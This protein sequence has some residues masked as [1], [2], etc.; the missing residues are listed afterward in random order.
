MQCTLYKSVKTLDGKIEKKVENRVIVKAFK[1]FLNELMKVYDQ[2][3]STGDNEMFEANSYNIINYAENTFDTIYDQF[4][5]KYPHDNSFLSFKLNFQSAVYS[6]SVLK[7]LAIYIFK[8]AIVIKAFQ[9]E[10]FFYAKFITPENLK[11][12]FKEPT[13]SILNKTC[14]LIDTL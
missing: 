7:I 1:S 13:K 12:L 2:I 8:M 10:D 4:K 3:N 5:K 11:K 9:E 6:L 14:K